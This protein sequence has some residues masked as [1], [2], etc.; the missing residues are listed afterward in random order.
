MRDGVKRELEAEEPR[1]LVERVS[2][3]GVVDSNSEFK[4]SERA[5]CT[6][7]A[8]AEAAAVPSGVI[9]GGSEESTIVRNELEEPRR[10]A[11]ASSSGSVGTAVRARTSSMET[12]RGMEERLR[13]RS[14]G[15]RVVTES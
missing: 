4:P 6:A 8:A 14:P 13:E 1:E 3:G 12:R 15:S 10:V 9:C 7:E 5:W 2:A 11:G